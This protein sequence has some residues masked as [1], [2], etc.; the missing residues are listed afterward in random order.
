MTDPH[1]EKIEVLEGKYLLGQTLSASELHTASTL[2]NSENLRVAS[3]ACG[4]ILREQSSNEAV[5]QR[6]ALRLDE[7]CQ[8]YMKKDHTYKNELLVTLI[9]IPILAL[10]RSRILEEFAY[11]AASAKR[12]TLRANAMA[13]LGRLALLGRE[14]ATK[15][16]TESLADPNEEVRRNATINLEGV[17]RPSKGESPP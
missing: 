4:A 13:V 3:I 14:E 6:A 16:L 8:E 9:V 11:R 15:L 12:F 7:L 1:E 2:M 10:R 17:R 5:K